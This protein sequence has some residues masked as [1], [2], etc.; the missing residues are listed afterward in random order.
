MHIF[1][2][3]EEIQIYGC[4]ALHLLLVKVPEEQLTEFVESKDHLV[5]LKVLTKFKDTESVIFEAF[6]ALLP[7]AG[8]CKL[9]VVFCSK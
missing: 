9:L 6:R 1:P 8:P 4:L 3:H 7:L 2:D 5:I